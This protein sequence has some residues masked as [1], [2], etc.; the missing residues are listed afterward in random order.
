MSLI[1]DSCQIGA[2]SNFRFHTGHFIKCFSLPV[3]V[4]WWL[5]WV[6]TVIKS[7]SGALVNSV[8]VIEMTWASSLAVYA[9]KELNCSV[10]M[11]EFQIIIICKQQRNSILFCRTFSSW[12]LQLHVGAI[13]VTLHP[14]QLVGFAV[15]SSPPP[16]SFVSMC[17]TW[18]FRQIHCRWIRESSH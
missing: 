5:W 16:A 11:L 18:L 17:L 8:K 4:C 9:L 2:I 3:V 13:S 14:V 12:S 10:S 6:C 1:Q 15:S 7:F